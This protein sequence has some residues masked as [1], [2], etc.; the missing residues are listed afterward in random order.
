MVTATITRWSFLGLV[1]SA[2]C[3]T[4]CDAIPVSQH[5]LSNAENSVLDEQLYGHWDV[6]HDDEKKD[7]EKKAD[8]PAAPADKAEA[9]PEGQPRFIIGKAT[10]HER[11]HELLSVQVTDAGEI[12]TK[13]IPFFATT[14]GER[15]IISIKM[16]E[17]D[18][19][20]EFMLM[21]Y[22]FVNPNRLL[23]YMMDRDVITNAIKRG[24]L[25]G[26][27]KSK[28]RDGDPN[29]VERRES[30]RITATAEKLRDFLKKHEKTAF[31]SQ[32]VFRLQRASQQ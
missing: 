24:E 14:L 29:V 25:D 7:G 22:E 31:M 20:A 2:L 5:P 10:D 32:H 23:V 1:C 30:I 3:L 17:P 28:S 12:E 6:Y 18:A 4:G 16:S 19:T 26:V 15:K 21:R 8:E 9:D 27:V 13:R 11:T